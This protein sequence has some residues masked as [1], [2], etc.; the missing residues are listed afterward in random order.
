MYR[1][2]YGTLDVFGGALG[3]GGAVA[4]AVSEAAACAGCWEPCACRANS[5]TAATMI[6][7]APSGKDPVGHGGGRPGI[8]GTV[9]V[10]VLVLVLT[11]TVVLVLVLGVVV[12]VVDSVPDV[13]DGVVVV[14][15]V[16][17]VSVVVDVELVGAVVVVAVRDVLDSGVRGLGPELEPPKIAKITNARRSAPSAPNP[18]R[19]HGLRYHGTGGPPGGPGG[20]WPAAL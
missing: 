3:G 14:V 6:A 7:S 9:T 1:G 8:D 10:T 17:V 18:T 15:V 16:S 19:A 11:V 2:V 20:C 12:V 5:S 4:V 13:V